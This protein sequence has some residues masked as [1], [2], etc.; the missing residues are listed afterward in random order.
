VPLDD[1][2]VDEKMN[3]V[4][5]PVAIRDT[6]VTYLRNKE[7]KQVLVQWQHRRG[8]DLTWETEEEMR[9]HYPFLFGK[10]I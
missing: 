5:M 8:A 9:E 6:K 7:I 2:V 1:I 4:E 10:Y 3:Y